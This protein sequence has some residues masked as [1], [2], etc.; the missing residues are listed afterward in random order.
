[1]DSS[2]NDRRAL[3]RH[4]VLRFARGACASAAIAACSASAAAPHVGVQSP[5]MQAI[6]EAWR[7][8]PALSLQ[9][10]PACSAA[11][12]AIPQVSCG[13]RPPIDGPK[14]AA[15]T[16]LAGTTATAGSAQTTGVRSTRDMHQLA[17]IDLGITPEDRASMDRAVNA[18]DEAAARTDASGDVLIDHA[19]AHLQRY[20]QHTPSP[21]C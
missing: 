9:S 18:L 8:Y 10:A 3:V 15:L 7:G 2:P 14:L 11:T 12:T 20:A 13:T 16:A 4:A 21:T 1:M 17:L 19:A 6:A 5:A